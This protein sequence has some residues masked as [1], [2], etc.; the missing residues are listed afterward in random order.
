MWYAVGLRP[1]HVLVIECSVKIITQYSAG[2]DLAFRKRE[3][4]VL[5]CESLSVETGNPRA[6]L[7]FVDE[8][9]LFV[10]H[11]SW[12]YPFSSKNEYRHMNIKNY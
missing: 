9:V 8:I 3:S 12:F 2:T 10:C 11:K 7:E 4:S 1:F 5:Y 6:Q